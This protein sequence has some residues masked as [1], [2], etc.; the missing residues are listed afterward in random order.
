MAKKS[1]AIGE[2]KNL[3]KTKR[4]SMWISVLCHWQGK[5]LGF[6]SDKVDRFEDFY[7]LS[8][9][10]LSTVFNG[11]L[12][13]VDALLGSMFCHLKENNSKQGWIGTDGVNRVAGHE[14]GL[15]FC[16]RV[17]L[18]ARAPGPDSPRPSRS[19]PVDYR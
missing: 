19:T 1:V 10:F 3:G 18:M 11:Q 6:G 8:V 2:A 13:S 17:S 5:E 12:M 16:L 7:A 14:P 15:K 9:F 4:T